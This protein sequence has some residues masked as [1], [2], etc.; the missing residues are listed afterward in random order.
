ME[1]IQAAISNDR[2]QTTEMSLGQVFN[3]PTFE[4]F[5][6]KSL[7]H[8]EEVAP[9]ICEK[10]GLDMETDGTLIRLIDAAE[11]ELAECEE[12][13]GEPCRKR[14]QQYWLPVIKPDGNGSW[15]IPRALC[16]FGEMRRLK[17]GCELC[18]IPAAYA[19]KTFADYSETADNRRAL[20]IAKWFIAEKPN[21]GV[22]LYG[23]CG[24]GKTF[25]AS[26]IAKDFLLDFGEVVFGD[27]PSLLEEIKRTFN[28]ATKD[29]GAIL[30][31]YCNCDLLVLDD[32]GA[33]QVTEWN[34]GVLYQIINN[35][36]NANK[37]LIITSN[38]DLDGLEEKFGKADALS[39][40]RIISRLSEMCYQGFLG[41]LDRR[42]KS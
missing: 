5:R 33:G 14:I 37:P 40:K 39:A 4:E 30:D 41:T 27:V 29:G 36:Y 6:A 25:L 20:K 18:K 16:K 34:V 42:R 26:L 32:L 3:I 2:P 22:Y 13:T 21:K 23:G 28:D 17:R 12:C 7:A 38:F 24:T 10:Y 19:G 35:R 8:F 31:R 11:N 15:Y 9:R 1:A